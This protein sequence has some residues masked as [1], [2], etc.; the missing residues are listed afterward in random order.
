MYWYVRTVFRLEDIILGFF[1]SVLGVEGREVIISAA[2]LEAAARFR[3]T[4]RVPLS[5]AART[6]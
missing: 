4:S 1:L 6:S 5:S 3:C 2:G